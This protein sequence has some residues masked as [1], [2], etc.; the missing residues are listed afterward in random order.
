MILGRKEHRR[1]LRCMPHLLIL[2]DTRHR[3][4]N[5]TDA[6]MAPPSRPIVAISA[7]GAVTRYHSKRAA[8]DETRIPAASVALA[9]SNLALRDG[10]IWKFEDDP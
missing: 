1:T 3:A 10:F 6:R 7:T 2:I 4:S 5:S 8:S 9:A